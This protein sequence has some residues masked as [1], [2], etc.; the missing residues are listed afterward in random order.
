MGGLTALTATLGH[1]YGGGGWPSGTVAITVG[2]AGVVAGLAL[3]RVAWTAP[4]LFLGL[5]AAQVAVHALLW[6]G[7]GSSAVH[8]RLAAFAAPGHDGLAHGTATPTPHMVAGHLLAVAV[9]A[10]VLVSA[11]RAASLLTQVARRL[12]PLWTHVDAP[13]PAPSCPRYVDRITVLRRLHHLVTV[14]G[15]APPS[16]LVLS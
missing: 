7:S 11:E 16:A 5:A 9:T 13:P 10:V 6:I 1:A 3:A 2:L 15:H 12:C 4:R 8:P 14:R